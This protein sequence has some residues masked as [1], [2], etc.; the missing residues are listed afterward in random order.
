MGN[1]YKRTDLKCQLGITSWIWFIKEKSI[2]N[3]EPAFSG[4]ED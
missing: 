4:N 2:E 1:S 3:A